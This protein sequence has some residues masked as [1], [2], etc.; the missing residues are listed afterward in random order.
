MLFRALLR[1]AMEHK[2]GV[3]AANSQN[4]EIRAFTELTIRIVFCLFLIQR[5]TTN[6]GLCQLKPPPI[7]ARYASRYVHGHS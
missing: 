2:V 6:L 3:G 7:E 4:I 5:T 1:W